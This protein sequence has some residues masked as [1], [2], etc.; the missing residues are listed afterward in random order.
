MKKTKETFLQFPTLVL[1]RSGS[2]G[3]LS[4]RKAT[5]AKKQY[6]AINRRIQNQSQEFTFLLRGTLEI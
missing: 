4:G 2:T 6:A 5:P 3:I 1:S